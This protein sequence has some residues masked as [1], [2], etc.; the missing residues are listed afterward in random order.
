MYAPIFRAP[1][2]TNKWIL[3][4]LK[5]ET[6]NDNNNKGLQHHTIYKG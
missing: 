3:T 2:Y 6:D 5:G 4:G 1:K